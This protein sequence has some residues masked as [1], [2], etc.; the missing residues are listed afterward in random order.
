[1][2]LNNLKELPENSY[3]YHKPLR[4]S[5]MNPMRR[6]MK[7][8]VKIISLRQNS[9][10]VGHMYDSVLASFGDHGGGILL[11]CVKSISANSENIMKRV[12]KDARYCQ[13]MMEGEKM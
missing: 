11:S 6:L 4:V 10:L 7:L 2:E 3:Q 1:M 8:S 5:E 12:P 9:S 13:S